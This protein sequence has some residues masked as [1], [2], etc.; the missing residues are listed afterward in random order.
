MHLITI[1]KSVPTYKQPSKQPLQHYVTRLYQHSRLWA[2]IFSAFKS[3]A[4][5]VTPCSIRPSF[6]CRPLVG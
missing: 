3:F 4:K 6:L 5:I 1:R 2:E